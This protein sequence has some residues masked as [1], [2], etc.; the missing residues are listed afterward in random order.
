MIGPE[1]W[2]IDVIDFRVYRSHF[3]VL[4]YFHLADLSSCDAR[5]YPLNAPR[6]VAV[7]GRV[8]VSGVL[9]YS[10]EDEKAFLRHLGT[11]GTAMN[12][13]KSQTLLGLVSSGAHIKM[14]KLTKTTSTSTIFLY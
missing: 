3:K 4:K 6:G 5:I 13:T 14:S 2:I 8:S 1:R 7:N 10:S 12:K 9:S 11:W